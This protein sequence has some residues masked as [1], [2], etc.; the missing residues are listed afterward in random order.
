MKIET[1]HITLRNPDNDADPGDCAIGHYVVDDNLV[2]LTDHN[3]KPERKPGK[4]GEIAVY[5]REVGPGETPKQV[6]GRLLREKRGARPANSF[7]APIR[8]PPLSIY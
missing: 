1:V 8:Y 6:A 3:G 5:Q 2:T 7:N 4:A